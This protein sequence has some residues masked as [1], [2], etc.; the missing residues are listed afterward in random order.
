MAANVAETTNR[1][2]LSLTRPRSGPQNDRDALFYLVPVIVAAILFTIVPFVY[3]VYISFTNFNR[4]RHYQSFE[5]IG[6]EN[7]RRVFE[8]G[9][10]FFPILN[11]T[12]FW[13]VLTTVINVGIGAFLALLL[14]HPHLKE[15]NVYRTLLVIPWALPFI[16]LVQVWTGVL[17]QDG[18]FNQV[19]GYLG[20][21]G[22]RWLGETATPTASRA[23]L[24]MVNLWF[25]YPFFMTV[26]LA[27]LQ[28]IPRDLY[29]VADLDGAG[30]WDR[31][32]TITFPFLRTAIT[33]LL[34][35]QA[36]F[37]FNNAGVIILLTNGRP[38]GG[39]GEKW[40]RTDSLASYAYKLIY[41]QGLYGRAAAF[42]I[43]IFFVIAA[44]TIINSVVSG[45]FKEAA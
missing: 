6:L 32:N 5:L 42:S 27:A 26:C 31:F 34:I 8:S 36:A 39:P 15:R 22:P 18:P 16:L 37:Q 20:L 30:W 4:F 43:V 14:N 10:E 44:F 40:G 21:N 25:T 24:L 17:N 41:E 29:E 33:P 3:S 1:P 19:L 45:S 13:M 12:I 7:Y 35:T 23:A 28:A 2:R 9:S 38:L 11:W